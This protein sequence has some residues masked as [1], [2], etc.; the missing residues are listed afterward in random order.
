MMP[1]PTA[2]GVG[3]GADEE[4]GPNDCD[5]VGAGA[6]MVAG[7]GTDAGTGTGSVGA[8][9]GTGVDADAGDEDGAVTEFAE[10]EGNVCLDA[11]KGADGLTFLAG[12]T[13]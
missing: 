9:V 8:V 13:L 5:V 11:E 4:L 7:V 12:G 3:T 2:A 10:P 1:H 6:G